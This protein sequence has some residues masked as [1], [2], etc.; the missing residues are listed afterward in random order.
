MAQLDAKM[1]TWRQRQE[2]IKAIRYPTSVE[3]ISAGVQST[4]QESKEID[5]P[6]KD[7]RE[8]EEEESGDDDDDWDPWLGLGGVS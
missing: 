2:A 3:E 7:Q 1:K 8:M 6:S 4:M 5:V